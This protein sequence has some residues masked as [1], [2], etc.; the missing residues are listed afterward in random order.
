MEKYSFERIKEICHDFLSNCTD[1]QK[2]GRGGWF[3]INGQRT[4]LQDY[5]SLFHYCGMPK[6]CATALKEKWDSD[7]LAN[8]V[9]EL[10]LSFVN[11]INNGE[12]NREQLPIEDELREALGGYGIITDQIMQTIV[13]VLKKHNSSKDDESL[14][15]LEESEERIK[16]LEDAT[17]EYMK[18]LNKIMKFFYDEI[19]NRKRVIPF[20]SKFLTPF[21]GFEPIAKILDF[22]G[23]PEKDNKCVATQFNIGI[24][25]S[26]LANK[27]KDNG[28]TEWVWTERAKNVMNGTYAGITTGVIVNCKQQP[29]DESL[30]H[31]IYFNYDAF[32]CFI[33]CMR[34]DGTVNYDV[35]N[36]LGLWNK[37]NK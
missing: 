15:K 1:Y 9:Y 37:T 23:V 29:L 35:M 28:K 7:M 26:K 27:T 17:D 21:K 3:L 30:G 25:N 22:Y 5:S 20:S 34:Q 33:D 13:P 36:A 18:Q 4:K 24:Q 2:Y 11:P 19:F 14:K 6:I 10:Y 12:T 32:C 31:E 8:K 16:K